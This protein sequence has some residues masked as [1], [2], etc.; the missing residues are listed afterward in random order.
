MWLIM[1]NLGQE[2][3]G[4][5]CQPECT[6]G[7]EEHRSTRSSVHLTTDSFLALSFG[8]RNGPRD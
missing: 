2:G 5:G 1:N 4:S 3:F 6:A 7:S 8:D